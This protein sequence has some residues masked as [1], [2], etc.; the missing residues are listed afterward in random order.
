MIGETASALGMREKPAPSGGPAGETCGAGVRALLVEDDFAIR[1][2]VFRRLR[3][4][5]FEVMPVVDGETALHEGLARSF[6][7][8]ILDL[9]LPKLSG[10][11]VIRGLRAAGKDTP[12]IVITGS[13][14]STDCVTGLDAGADD[15]LVKP[16]FLDVF[17]ARVQA[18]TRRYRA[19]WTSRT[20]VGQ[21]EYDH[22]RRAF[23]AHGGPVFFTRREADIL[24]ALMNPPGELV[25]KDYLV[26][27]LSCWDYS[28][29]ANLV[30][31][32]VHKLRRR[33]ADLG[34]EISTIRGLGYV[35]KPLEEAEASL[36]TPAV[37]Q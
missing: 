21:L 4:S 18:L 25:R 7:I 35:M 26:R 36:P 16:F 31:V 11:E 13:A 9:G 1:E 19:H 30:E 32:Y 14:S 6:D 15:Y 8:I 33:L 10:F 29:T 23:H 2:A 37:A 3:N 24:A 34:V 22:H 28:V 5:G 17:H 12:I 27:S 20:T